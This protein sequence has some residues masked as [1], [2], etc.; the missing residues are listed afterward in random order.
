MV[1]ATDFLKNEAYN[2]DMG[3]A[4]DLSGPYGDSTE[5]D[6]LADTHKRI[7]GWYTYF[8][9]NIDTYRYDLLFLYIEQWDPYLRSVRTQKKKT[10]L[11]VNY[12]RQMIERLVGE[13]SQNDP[14]LIVSPPEDM[15]VQDEDVT[16][17][18]GILRQS[19][20]ESKF[21]QVKTA[22]FRYALSAGYSAILVSYDYKHPKTYDKKL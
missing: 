14:S 19:M 7:N 10:I 9:P 12:L 20:Y 4:D 11:Q 8:A 3:T 6:I 13:E 16:L 2:A 17:R 18:E 5:A 15:P 21:K 1:T 22:A